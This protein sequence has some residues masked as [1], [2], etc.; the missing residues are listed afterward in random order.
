MNLDKLD[1]NLNEETENR[2]QKWKEKWDKED[3]KIEGAI[4]YYGLYDNKPVYFK[5]DYCGRL[6]SY[7]NY[8]GGVIIAGVQDLNTSYR[9][10]KAIAIMTEFAFTMQISQTFLIY[11]LS[12]Y[13]DGN[14]LDKLVQYGY[15][16]VKEF[17]NIKTSNDCVMLI[18][19]NPYV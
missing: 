12:E 1:N 7:P 3:V 19:N 16:I 4:R 2:F 15:N 5:N 14:I 8:C 9:Y 6:E 13:N 17:R 18:K 10:M 11:N